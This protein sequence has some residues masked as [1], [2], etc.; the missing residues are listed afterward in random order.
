MGWISEK[1]FGEYAKMKSYLTYIFYFIYVYYKIVFASKWAP[2]DKT[3][4]RDYRNYSRKGRSRYA[5][6]GWQLANKLPNGQTFPKTRQMVSKPIVFGV[7][8]SDTEATSRDGHIAT[9]NTRPPGRVGA[10]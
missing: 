3:L 7:G 2:K 4:D 10:E 9:R 6:K 5:N 8:T 1:T